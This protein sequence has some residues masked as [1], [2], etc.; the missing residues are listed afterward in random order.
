MA[1]SEQPSNKGI[2]AAIIAAIAAILVAL[3]G[4]FQNIFKEDVPQKATKRETAAPAPA[5]APDNIQAG[6]GA[7]VITNSTAGRDI[8][9]NANADGKK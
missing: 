2:L 9:V 1:T 6:S 4:N 7:V 3:F 8:Q 5:A